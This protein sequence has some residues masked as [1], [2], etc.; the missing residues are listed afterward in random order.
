M[1]DQSDNDINNYVSYV[2]AIKK[3]KAEEDDDELEGVNNA[4]KEKRNLLC[5]RKFWM[6][7]KEKY[8][9]YFAAIL[10]TSSSIGF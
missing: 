7:K 5:L 8:W 6:R 10:C 2:E 9:I 4:E 1:L 3:L